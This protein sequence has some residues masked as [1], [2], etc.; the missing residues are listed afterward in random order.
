MLGS[1]KETK[2]APLL[3][4][5]L[6]WLGFALLWC[7]PRFVSWVGRQRVTRYLVGKGV[8][9]LGCGGRDATWLS[10]GSGASVDTS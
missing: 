7:A 6:C 9:R 5:V 1:E 2:R 10:V 4:L 3:R 8:A